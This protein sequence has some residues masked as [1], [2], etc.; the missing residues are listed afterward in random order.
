L[1]ALRR[2]G[3]QANKAAVWQALRLVVRR[4]LDGGPGAGGRIRAA[5]KGLAGLLPL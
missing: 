2:S 4:R 5:E 1:P 3:E